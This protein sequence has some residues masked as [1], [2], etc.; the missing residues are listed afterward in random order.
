VGGGGTVIP[1]GLIAAHI[2]LVE[3]VKARFYA[4][5][6]RPERSRPTHE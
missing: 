6:D 3:F 5:Q 2:V 1:L 4:T